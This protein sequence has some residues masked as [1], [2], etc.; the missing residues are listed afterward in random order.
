MQQKANVK[1]NTLFNTI[2]SVFGIIYPLI[3]F[4]YISRVLMA[5]NV[6]KINFGN[7]VVSYFSLIASLGVTTYAVR[8]CS[9][10]KDDREQL[11][12]T[13]SQILSINILSTVIAYLALA[14]TLVVARP[15][16]N[17]MTLIC[18]Q[19]SII[20]FATLGAD[21][22]NTAMED[23]KFIAIRTMG[24][25]ILSL[26]LLFVF[27]RR[28]ED[29]LVYAVIS[30]VASSG[31]NIINIFY[32]RRFCRTRFTL[33]MDIKRH[34]PPILLLFSMILS[35]TIYCNSD[36][37]MLGLMRG[38]REVGLY[39]TSVKI[40][41][42]V[43]TVIAS[44]AWVVIPQLSAGFAK[45][46]YKEV[47]RLLKYSLN[48]IVVL[49]LPCLV[50]INVITK[51]LIYTLAGKE[52]M[53]A[54]VSLHILT[55]SLFISLIGG[56]IGNMM[57]LPAGR[58]KVCLTACAASAV[59]NIILNFILIPQFGMNAAAA[60]TAVAELV[61]LVILVRYIDKNIRIEGFVDMIKA[62][63]VGIM[64]IVVIGLVVSHLFHSYF[65]VALLTIMLSGIS[66]LVTMIFMKNEFVLSFIK[67]VMNRIKRR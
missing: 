47:N 26:V 51:P 23:F 45:K 56:W 17:Y 3:T 55:I 18:I 66:Y 44:V 14:V 53:D 32:R 48:F 19:S 7:S 36:M 40:Y 35:Q 67:P 5:E 21:W 43:N 8:E 6:G 58:D 4:P 2:K 33:D 64:E 30:V 29:Y 11:G 13:A 39:S 34:L 20:L 37:T 24:M 49:G 57:M 65:T 12:K 25:Q 52:Y 38:D 9:K 60:T 41:N 28:P 42:L 61:G 31:A 50:G 15:L 62:P 16:D 59:I 10:V 1:A 63:L 27:V 46:D 54:S 22:L